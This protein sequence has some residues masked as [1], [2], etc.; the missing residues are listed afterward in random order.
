MKKEFSH[1]ENDIQQILEY[2]TRLGP[3][4]RNPS[5]ANRLQSRRGRQTLAA[6]HPEALLDLGQWPY[7]AYRRCS[8]PGILM[9]FILLP[10]HTANVGQPQMLPFGGQ[11]AMMAIEDGGVLGFLLK[12]AEPDAVDVRLSLYQ[13]LRRNRAS[14]VQT[15]SKV[16]VGREKEAE[17][18]VRLYADAPD[19]CES[20]SG[21]SSPRHVTEEKQTGIPTSHKER[22]VHDYR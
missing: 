9:T 17:A 6:L 19:A 14:R 1:F 11:G 5:Q 12:D 7:S 15:L 4:C 13:K 10:M 20:L 22:I 3:K 21:Q 16:R 18:E 2:V 8:S